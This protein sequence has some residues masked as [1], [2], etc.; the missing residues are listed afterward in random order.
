MPNRFG[1]KMDT[2][3]YLLVDKEHKK[4]KIG[5]TIDIADRS[6]RLS[7]DWGDLDLA[8]SYI[9]SDDALAISRLEKT[10]HFMFHKWNV[11]DANEAAGHTEWFSIDCLSNVLEELNRIGQYQDSNRAIIKGIDPSASHTRRAIKK[12][13]EL[14]Y[15]LFKEM[16]Y[17]ILH[18]LLLSP[19]ESYHVREVSRLI[20]ISPGSIH[21]ELRAL[22]DGTLLIREKVGNQVVYKANTD[23]E[24]Y[25]ELRSIL[26][27]IQ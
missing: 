21:R 17:R 16:R 18:L 10:L 3:L 8:E 25:D 2:D 20:A 7:R 27:K 6:N 13:T 23:C 24:I 22:T 12:S 14:G 4:F 1:L 19:E 15:L 26:E 11:R 9:V 5:L